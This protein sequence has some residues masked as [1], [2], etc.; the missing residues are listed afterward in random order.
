MENWLDDPGFEEGLF[1]SPWDPT[2]TPPGWTA[3]GSPAWLRT[4]EGLEPGDAHGGDAVVALEDGDELHQSVERLLTF[5]D[6]YVVR[7]W[8]RA[9]APTDAELAI[10]FLGASNAVL[11]ESVAP[12]T[13]WPDWQRHSLGVQGPEDLQHVAVSIRGASGTAW[14]DDIRLEIASA[15]PVTF[16]L[17]E[18]A[19][20]FEGFGVRVSPGDSA[21]VAE[22]MAALGLRFVR[23]AVDG[24]KDGDLLVTQAATG[25]APWLVTSRVVEDAGAW[26]DRVQALET[27]G[28]HPEAIELVDDTTIIDE[29]TY[30]AL[31][32]ATRSALD[33]AQVAVPIAGPGAPLRGH[34]ARDFLFALESDAPIGAWSFQT[35]DDAAIAGEPRLAIA[36]ADVRGTFDF[37]GGTAGRPIWVTH[38]DTSETTF[39][40]V[41]WP[42]PGS[43]VD[44]NVTASAGYAVRVVENA[45]GSIAG[46]AARAYLGYAV[47]GPSIGSGL[48]TA[49]GEDKPLSRAIELLGPLAAGATVVVPPEQ[50]GRALYVGVFTTAEQIAVVVTNESGEPQALDVVLEGASGTETIASARAFLRYD[51]GD[52]A[53]KVPDTV[54][55]FDISIDATNQDG[56]IAI[57]ADLL[58]VSVSVLAFDR[59]P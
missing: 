19:H 4:G 48:V 56:K 27:L 47:D 32:D 50:T 39:L 23:V 57:E 41:T 49:A 45:L 8:T 54:G 12:I 51:A 17:G 59:G 40:D 18:T 33:I 55:T 13:G 36:W 31:V 9:D 3:V 6:R 53:A 52:P 46:G 22:T 5:D 7:A 2:A 15:D 30:T 24:A 21:F 34:E 11:A 20:A 38:L 25:K 14:F 29:P 16:D 44:F 28:I 35:G 43:S 58:P 42:S 1:T 10:A 26:V 37:L